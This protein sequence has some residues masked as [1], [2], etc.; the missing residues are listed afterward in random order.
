MY[1]RSS[2]AL[3]EN[4]NK[5]T[6]TDF[7]DWLE[8]FACTQAIRWGLGFYFKLEELDDEMKAIIAEYGMQEMIEKEIEPYRGRFANLLR[9]EMRIVR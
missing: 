5:K 9:K 2:R 7:A 6:V 8:N 1:L 3:E 4:L